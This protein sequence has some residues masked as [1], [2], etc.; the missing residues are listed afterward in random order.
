M[1]D[2]IVTIG[3]IF[4][5]AILVGGLIFLVGFGA[6]FVGYAFYHDMTISE[7]IEED[8][9]QRRA[10]KKADEKRKKAFAEIERKAKQENPDPESVFIYSR[11]ILNSRAREKL[12]IKM[13]QKKANK[14]FDEY[15][16]K[17]RELK[18]PSVVFTDTENVFDKQL[19]VSEKM[20]A[21]NINQMEQQIDDAIKAFKIQCTWRYSN[22]FDSFPLGRKLALGTEWYFNTRPEIKNYPSLH[23]KLDLLYLRIRGVCEGYKRDELVAQMENME[24]DKT[25]SSSWHTPMRDK[26]VYAVMAKILDKPNLEKKIELTLDK[27]EKEKFNKQKE[28]L[29]KDYQKAFGDT[30]P[31]DA[32]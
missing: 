27:T 25:V 5:V 30:I 32:Y 15:A 23:N 29:S 10:M 11:V 24:M 1:N 6:C 9:E 13:S 4:A 7:V 28:L 21:I 17:A 8:R 2:I 3:K 19:I 14:L 31:N 18:A 22:S 16:D 12:G 26:V 20:Q